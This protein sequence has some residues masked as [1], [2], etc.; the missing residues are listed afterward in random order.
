MDAAAARAALSA[1]SA[2]RERSD[3]NGETAARLEQEEQALV[4]RLEEL[5]R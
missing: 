1:V 4:G 2:A 3:L 5:N